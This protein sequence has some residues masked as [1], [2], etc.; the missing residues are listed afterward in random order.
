VK[1]KRK[2]I[3]LSDKVSI[4]TTPHEI[5]KALIFVF[6]STENYKLWHKDHILCT[7]KEGKN[8]TVGSVLYAEEY[9]HGTKHK[10]VFLV[11]SSD[12]KTGVRYR[13]TFPYSMICKEGSFEMTPISSGITMLEAKLLLNIPRFMQ[14]IFRKRIESIVR[15]MNEEGEW[16]KRYLE[17]RNI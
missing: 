17:E 13:L 4:N 16:L 11:L 9:L 15:H 7:W 14:G 8:F 1:R 6:E 12:E 10:M 5:L 2:M 3:C